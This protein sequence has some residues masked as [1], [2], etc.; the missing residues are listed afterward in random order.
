MTHYCSKLGSPVVWCQALAEVTGASLV[1]HGPVQHEG[2]SGGAGSGGTAVPQPKASGKGTRHG[3]DSEGPGGCVLRVVGG[4]SRWPVSGSASEDALQAGVT[5]H[6]WLQGS[7]AVLQVKPTVHHL[8]E[9]TV[10]QAAAGPGDF[11]SWLATARAAFKARRDASGTGK[12][13]VRGP[14]PSATVSILEARDK[15]LRL[16]QTSRLAVQ[17]LPVLRPVAGTGSAKPP[18]GSP[19]WSDIVARSPSPATTTGSHLDPQATCLVRSPSVPVIVNV[20]GS[21]P[22]A[23]AR[24][25]HDLARVL[26]T[27]TCKLVGRR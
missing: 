11:E 20:T 15:A 7:Y 4:L 24:G 14:G 27:I 13:Q 6:L 3:G 22:E 5:W 16:A 1:V 25:H 12:M 17:T 19:T 8:S 18:S 23:Q 10:T 9:T 21:Q 2:A 26:G